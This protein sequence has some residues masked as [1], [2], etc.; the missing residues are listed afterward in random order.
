MPSLQTGY[1]IVRLARRTP[2]PAV[3]EFLK[4]LREVE[5]SL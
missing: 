5:S 4:L 1:G 3:M 2:S